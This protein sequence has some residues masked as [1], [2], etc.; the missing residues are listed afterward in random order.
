MGAITMA[1]NPKAGNEFQS[2]PALFGK[3]IEYNI[4]YDV[5]LQVVSGDPLL[6]LSSDIDNKGIVGSEEPLRAQSH[7]Y[8]DAK[9]YAE[10]LVHIINGTKRIALLAKRGGC[11]FEAKA[12]AAMAI[13]A[14]LRAKSREHHSSSTPIISFVVVYDDVARPALVPMSASSSAAEEDLSSISL[15]F[16]S[17]D[18][19]TALLKAVEKTRD[20]NGLPIT[21]DA[22]APWGGNNYIY[23]SNLYG[24]NYPREFVLAALAGFFMC[25]TLLGC[26]LMCAQAGIISTDGNV[27]VLSRSLADEIM[28]RRQST[29]RNAGTSS[30]RLKLLTEEQVMALPIVEF[31]SVSRTTVTRAR[32]EKTES[33]PINGDLRSTDNRAHFLE[34]SYSLFDQGAARDH[35]NMCDICLEDYTEGEHLLE[36]PACGHTY[37]TRCIKPWL[38]KRSTLCPHCRTDVLACDPYYGSVGWSDYSPLRYMHDANVSSESSTSDVGS[39]NGGGGDE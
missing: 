35:F 34:K 7:S 9:E 23:Q 28:A 29:G 33:M 6:C 24:E 3:E 25:L 26:L 1:P 5:T 22:S 20:N 30:S 13:D 38:T 19:G 31:R 36:L 16:V 37:H 21:I 11:S 12:R 15:V 4:S 32:V 8:T 10:R 17:Y 2:Q 27:I 14:E 39:D 18:T